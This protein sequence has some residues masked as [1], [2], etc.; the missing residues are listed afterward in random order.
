MTE[1]A[2][3]GIPYT[4]WLVVLAFAVG[5]AGYAA[6]GW[7]TSPKNKYDFMSPKFQWKRM[8]KTMA[9]GTVIGMVTFGMATAGDVE[10]VTVHLAHGGDNVVEPQEFAAAA[11]V[12]FGLVTTMAWSWKR[13][14]GDQGG[15]PE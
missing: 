7:Y 13:V 1:L 11:M 5:G 10:T 12:A 14:R 9:A 3:G 15:R 6:F 2:F 4:P 8:F